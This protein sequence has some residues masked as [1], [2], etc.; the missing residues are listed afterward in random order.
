MVFEA[1]QLWYSCLKT[2]GEDSG[3]TPDDLEHMM[4]GLER[5]HRAAVLQERAAS[6]S[7]AAAVSHEE[8]TADVWY[9][10]DLWDKVKDT[11]ELGKFEFYLENWSLMIR[12][13]AQFRGLLTRIRKRKA[14]DAAE[15][16]VTG[17][18]VAAEAVAA[19]PTAA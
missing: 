7:N 4:Y 15:P 16:E 1:Q 5:R 19:E 18:P 11:A 6:S 2:G 10:A 12:L 17:A 3:I 9:M 13:Q 8:A 14:G